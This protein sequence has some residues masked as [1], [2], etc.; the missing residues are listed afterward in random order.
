M[1]HSQ[2]GACTILLYF[3]I[4]PI[5]TENQIEVVENDPFAASVRRGTAAAPAHLSRRPATDWVSPL[6]SRVGVDDHLSSDGSHARLPLE[7]A[8]EKC[9]TRLKKFSLRKS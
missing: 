1:A 5:S 9:P 8:V 4:V 7:N 6:R 2:S 3:L